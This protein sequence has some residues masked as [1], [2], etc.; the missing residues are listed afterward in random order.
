MYRIADLCAGV[1][2]FH[3]ALKKLGIEAAMAC[4][5][6]KN[7]QSTYRFN[8]PETPILDDIRQMKGRDM[9]GAEIMCA[10][11]PCQAFSIAGY[12]KGFEDARGTIFFD[13]ARI[14]SEAK[15]EILFLENVENLIRHKNGQTFKTI[16]R[17]LESDL[18]YKVCYKVLDARSF[19]MYQMRK[20]T[21]IICFKDHE[22]SYRF[23]LHEGGLKPPSNFSALLDDFEDLNKKYFIKEDSHLAKNYLGLIEHKENPEYI[24]QF[25][26]HYWREYK[27]RC[28]TLTANMGAGGHNVPFIYDPRESPPDGHTS[29]RKFTPMEAFRLQGFGVEGFEFKLPEDSKDSHLYMQAGNAVPVRM[30]YEIAKNL[31]GILK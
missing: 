28:P 1:G 5:I 6:D 27:G 24:Y 30:I 20:R 21:I 13:L 19:G 4:E 9:L 22:L 11:F 2:G 26:R 23:Q 12:R 8:F 17:I 7:A 16:K 14:A 3:L 15:P 18:G 31:A 25:R 29:Y 10:G